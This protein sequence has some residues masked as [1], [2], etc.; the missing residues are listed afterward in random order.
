MKVSLS[1][2]AIRG[3]ARYLLQ[4]VTD[5]VSVAILGSQLSAISVTDSPRGSIIARN[6]TLAVDR[7]QVPR[8][9]AGWVVR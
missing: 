3:S 2:R 9:D 4:I 5:R 7:L 1:R 6:S 8:H